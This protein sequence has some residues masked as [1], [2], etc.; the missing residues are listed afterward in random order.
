MFIP[1]RFIAIPF[2]ELKLV[3][4]S[5]ANWLTRAVCSKTLVDGQGR[6]HCPENVSAD[7]LSLVGLAVA[8]GHRQCPFDISIRLKLYFPREN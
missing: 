7:S 8:N 5:I 3:N 6:C 2:S 1:I 4:K